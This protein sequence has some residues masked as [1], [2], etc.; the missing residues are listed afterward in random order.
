MT[1]PI[2]AIRPANMENVL[3]RIASLQPGVKRTETVASSANSDIQIAAL[4]AMSGEP[5]A[6]ES[7]LS[8]LTSSIAGLSAS[9]TSQYGAVGNASF[10][11]LLDKLGQTGDASSKG[12]VASALAWADTQV[13]V[14]YASV[15][16]Y[17]FGDVAWDGGAHLSVNGNGKTYQFPQGT[18]VYDCS[19]F[20]TAVW[21]K[22]GVDLA[23]YGAT[24][25]ESMA[26][27]VPAVSP[28][29][30]QKGDILLIDSDGDK[31]VDHC[32]PAWLCN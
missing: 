2:G 25:T 9:A 3:L 12:K 15:N 8:S 21:R 13:G 18:K 1:A 14:P 10:Q 11:S 7:Q 30:A 31:Q 27:K 32:H 17:R 19:G 16:P 6:D 20:V 24:T 28:A 4:T 26:A 29:N 23:T 5:S 22:A